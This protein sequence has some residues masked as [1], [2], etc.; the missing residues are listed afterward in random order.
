[1]TSF[2]A[3][4]VS[5]LRS[6]RPVVSDDRAL[7]SEPFR[8]LVDRLASLAVDRRDDVWSEFLANRS[9]G[10]A[11]IRA[12]VDADPDGPRPEPSEADG[13]GR[14]ATLADLSR[15][16]ST[17]P[18]LWQGWLCRGVLNVLASEPGTGKTRFGLDLAR[19][20]WSGESWPDGQA[21]GLPT[22][23]RTLW[24]QAD[25]AFMEMIEASRAFGLPEDAVLLGSSSNDPTGCLD[26]ARR[27]WSGESW[28]DG[29]A[30]GLPTGSRTLWI[31]ADQAFMEMI[32]ASRAFGLPEDAVL[33]GSSSND[34]TGCLDLDDSATLADIERRIVAER[35]EIVFIDTLGM[36]TNR[37]LCRPEDARAYFAPLMEMASRTQTTLLALTHLSKEKEALGRR[38]VEKAR[39]VLKMTQPDPEGQV[40]RR[41][42]WVDKSAVI[43]PPA[44]G[45]SMGDGGNNYDLTPPSETDIVRSSGRPPQARENAERFVIEA[46]EARGKTQATILQAEWLAAGG[47]KS[48]FWRARDELVK[49]DRIECK[50]KPFVLTLKATEEV[51]SDTT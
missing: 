29:Q 33:L 6:D 21:T 27:L 28:P 34:P 18:W 46:L 37:N 13:R 12:V 17:Q 20:L 11:L 42:F 44:L 2:D 47:T 41:R 25:Q 1:M 16:I 23:S 50:G 43:K 26:L 45:I 30:T 10:D 35:P 24:I 15:I 3:W 48:A 19:R 38:V 5:R 39:I 14:C 51:I 36:T 4:I 9:D 22:G 7:V 40:N 49:V 8:P 32:E 31:Q